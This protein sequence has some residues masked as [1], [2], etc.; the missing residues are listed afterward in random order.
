MKHCSLEAMHNFI[1]PNK[2]FKTPM[3]CRP[4]CLSICLSVCRRRFR[5]TVGF[6]VP[7]MRNITDM[8]L[9]FFRRHCI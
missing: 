9:Q 1:L 8:I 5:V 6:A 2:K 4:A 7:N 3:F